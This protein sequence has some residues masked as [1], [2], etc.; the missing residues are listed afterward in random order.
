MRTCIVCICPCSRFGERESKREPND[1]Y[2]RV[3]EF[4]FDVMYKFVNMEQKN[5]YAIEMDWRKSWKFS[6]LKHH[7]SSGIAIL[8]EAWQK[9]IQFEMT[10]LHTQHITN[11][12]VHCWIQFLLTF[13][14]N[15]LRHNFRIF[16]T[17]RIS[18]FQTWNYLLWIQQN[19][20][21]NSARRNGCESDVFFMSIFIE[22]F[23]SNLFP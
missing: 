6:N 11:N 21:F 16:C 20:H 14:H 4:Q 15:S 7:C 23:K 19:I 5:V 1:E 2:R 22:N 17:F 12:I 10:D 18:H 8:M 3:R 9:M 13:I